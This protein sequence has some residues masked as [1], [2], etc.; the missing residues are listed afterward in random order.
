MPTPLTGPGDHTVESAAQALLAGFDE[1]EEVENLPEQDDADEQPEEEGLQATETDETDESEEVEELDEDEAPEPQA[2][3]PQRF[4]VKV[5]GEETEVTLEELRAGYSRQS[6]YTRKTQEIAQ[7]R[8]TIEQEIQAAREER[9][10]Y[11][12]QLEELATLQPQVQEPSQEQWEALYRENPVEWVR[13]RE[14]WRESKEKREKLVREQQQVAFQQQQEQAQ[15]LQQ[16][17]TE[18]RQKLVEAIPEWRDP[19][20]AKREIG[21]IRR[22]AMDAGFT[23]NEVAQIYDH[24][25]VKVLHDA[26]RYRQLMNKQAALTP[27]KPKSPKTAPPGASATPAE[28]QSASAK[29]LKQRLRET[30]RLQDAA[31]LMEN[32][33]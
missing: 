10:R 26:V 1:H 18:E 4:T 9:E 3:E 17:V 20:V 22:F 16:T 6:D 2:E 13:Q 30:G 31:A 8:K 7:Q 33:L 32:M 25:A 21:E 23:E 27:M 29:K 24:R 12:K 15:K 14:L 11:A 5:D 19:E 28:Q